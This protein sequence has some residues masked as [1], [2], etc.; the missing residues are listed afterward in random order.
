MHYI[1]M[2]LLGLN[3]S[4]SYLISPPSPYVCH[5]GF[6]FIVLVFLLFWAGMWV[7]VGSVDAWV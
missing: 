1:G 3:V 2:A 6:Y 7:W 5:A 4:V